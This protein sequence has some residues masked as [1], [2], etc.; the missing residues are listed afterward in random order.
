MPKILIFLQNTS[1]TEV[2]T[3]M[4][5][6]IIG[7]MLVSMVTNI[8]HDFVSKKISELLVRGE[9]KNYD[10]ERQKAFIINFSHEIRNI[11]NI[12]MGQI[13]LS[14]LEINK[15]LMLKSLKEPMEKA[16]MSC[17]I[18]LQFINN[19]LDSGK[20]GIDEL[21]TVKTECDT[22][23]F[24]EKIWLISSELIK[25]KALK[26]SLV[27]SKTIPQRLKFDQLRL[28]QVLFNLVH[29][30]SKFT[31]QGQIT[32]IFDFINGPIELN[33]NHFHPL[34]LD[35]DGLFTKWV[36]TTRFDEK[37][38]KYSL[39]HNMANNLL[40]SP[41]GGKGLMKICI[42]DSGRGID[43]EQL[44]G[45]TNKDNQTLGNFDGDFYRA[46]DGL[47]LFISKKICEKMKG[48]FKIYSQNGKGTS[49][50]VLIP[51][52]IVQE[53]PIRQTSGNHNTT[54]NCQ[55]EITALVV[56]DEPL[57]RHVICTF[58]KNLKVTVLGEAVDGQDAYEKYV[59]LCS[60]NKKPKIVTMDINM[61]RC[62][63]KASSI[64]IREYEKIN[65][66]ESCDILFLSGNCF[67]SEIRD[68]ID[69]KKDIKARGFLKKPV[70]LEELRK[71]I[72]EITK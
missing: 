53:L 41:V 22:T 66:L 18:L 1:S 38:S 42:I 4:A 36:N 61:P 68:C 12:L 58:L 64:K 3:V 43:E 69:K 23:S 71:L 50:I 37:Y 65:N 14:L 19:I 47:G 24:I 27:V 34:P 32:M 63:G 26:G 46:T 33:E 51:V 59:M 10:T 70:C 54:Q 67:E 55:E 60:L 13:Q 17:N 35:E 45:L 49:I 52:T 5:D 15:N 48:D 6:I 28:T 29:N 62:N 72:A 9:Y 7:G 20:F 57:S 8:S 39:H 40:S 16:K 25:S 30:S 21:E 56:D 2:Y 11:I 31:D 44:S